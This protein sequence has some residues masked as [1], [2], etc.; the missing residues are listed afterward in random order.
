MPSSSEGL[1]NLK[2]SLKASVELGLMGAEVLH[3]GKNH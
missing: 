2:R 3:V 1:E